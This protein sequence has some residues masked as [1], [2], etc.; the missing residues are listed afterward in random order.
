MI[1]TT[2]LAAIAATLPP[3]VRDRYREEW[4]A[5]AA[6]AREAGISTSSLLPGALGVAVSI[7]RDDPLVAGVPP[8]RLIFRRLRVAVATLS[9]AIL[10]LIAAFLQ[11]FSGPLGVVILTVV[12]LMLVVAFACASGAIRAA[13]L[14]RGTRRRGAVAALL[15]AVAVL[16]LVGVLLV[17][18]VGALTLAGLLVVFLVVVTVEDPRTQASPLP[19]MRAGALALGCSLAILGTLALALLHV[20]VWNP[21]AK[22]PGLSLEQIYAQLAAAGELPTPALPVAVSVFWVLVCVA[23][24][25]LAVIPMPKVRRLMTARRIMGFGVV[26]VGLVAAGTFVLGFSMGMG[27]ADAF[28]TSG[29]DAASTGIVLSL[30]G[31]CAL[32]VGSFAG[33]LPS[34]LRPA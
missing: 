25:T 2:L 31:I 13:Q 8:R 4:A 14:A 27:I 23:V 1:A 5:D 28:A 29:G 12:A 10:L 21:L 11:G 26:G 32:I 19:R 20:F 34:R 30:M 6:G 15:A 16:L 17:P 22:L 7:D 33:L 3:G 24:I 9:A 18:L